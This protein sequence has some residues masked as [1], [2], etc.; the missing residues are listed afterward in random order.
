MVLLGLT[1]WVI[2]L[3]L[4]LESVDLGFS[5]LMLQFVGSLGTFL[6]LTLNDLC[7]H[8]LCFSFFTIDD[9]DEIKF[10]CP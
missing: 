2:A 5:G 9:T 4:H 10:E 7:L 1:R 8:I 6:N 3:L